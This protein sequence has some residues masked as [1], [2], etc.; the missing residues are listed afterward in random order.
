MNLGGGTKLV[1]FMRVMNVVS[2]AAGGK[3]P[4]E[5]YKHPSGV[6]RPFLNFPNIIYNIMVLFLLK[7]I[8]GNKMQ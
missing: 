3:S 7:Y 4:G 6:Q 1:S 5:Y 2:D 8:I